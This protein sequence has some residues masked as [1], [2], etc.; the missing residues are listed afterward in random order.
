MA[1]SR[2]LL[3]LAL[4]LLMVARAFGD[5]PM[6]VSYDGRSMIVNGEREL[7]FSG[8]IHYPR[9]PVEVSLTYLIWSRLFWTYG[10][11]LLWWWNVSDVAWHHKESQGRRVECYPDLC[12][13]EYPRARSREGNWFVH[14]KTST[15][16]SYL[17]WFCH[18]DCVAVQLWRKQRRC[19]VHQGNPK[20]RLVCHPQNWTIYR[21][22][23]ESRV[24]ISLQ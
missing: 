21:G 2:Q 14:I 5:K 16:C 3:R 7:L 6:G 17:E 9:M 1:I 11:T 8:S 19:Q 18:N 23:M 4:L 10:L 15:L 12:L 20:T 13:L 24:Y 22:W